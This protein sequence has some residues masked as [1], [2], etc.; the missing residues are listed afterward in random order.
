MHVQIQLDKFSDFAVRQSVEAVHV[1]VRFDVGLVVDG[2]DRTADIDTLAGLDGIY[3]TI[4]LSLIVGNCGSRSD[5][6]NR[7]QTKNESL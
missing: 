6:G 2:T 3:G 4:Y 1:L 7:E 5:C